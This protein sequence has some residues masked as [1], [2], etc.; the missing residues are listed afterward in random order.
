M[1]LY[2]YAPKVN[3]VKEKGLLSISKGPRD[4]RAY[5][6]RAGFHVDVAE[7]ALALFVRNVTVHE[8]FGEGGVVERLEKC[9][10]AEVLC[11]SPCV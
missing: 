5:A 8:P 3:T 7:Q 4:L 2:H 10:N 1:K 6:H 11:R 9:R